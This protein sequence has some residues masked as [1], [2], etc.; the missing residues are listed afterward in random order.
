MPFMKM[1]C[2]LSLSHTHTH[3]SIVLLLSVSIQFRLITESQ[4]EKEGQKNHRPSYLSPH[5]LLMLR[6]PADTITSLLQHKGLSPLHQLLPREHIMPQIL[7]YFQHMLPVAILQHTLA[8]NGYPCYGY[9]AQCHEDIKPHITSTTCAFNVIPPNSA[10]YSPA[11]SSSTPGIH[12]SPQSAFSPFAS[13]HSNN[14]PYNQRPPALCT[15]PP[16]V[17]IWNYCMRVYL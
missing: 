15:F 1:Y 8:S 11:S 14:S 17:K 6:Q 12:S 9:T 7:P 5:H 3:S 10:C 13:D 2:S 16:D 4:I